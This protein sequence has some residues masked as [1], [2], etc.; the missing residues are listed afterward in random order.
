MTQ[1]ERREKVERLIEMLKEE[2]SALIL[3]EGRRDMEALRTLGITHDIVTVSGKRMFDDFSFYE[4]KNIIILTDFDRTGRLLF[5]RLRKELE[6]MGYNPTI[7]Y[8]I[9]IKKLT[10]GYIKAIEELDT[11]VQTVKKG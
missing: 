5:N 9:Q 10:K 6:I 11:Y 8:W 7:Y 1:D 4:N 2:E 3:V